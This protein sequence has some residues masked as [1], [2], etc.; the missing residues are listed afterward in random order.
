MFKIV[1]EEV[2]LN[3]VLI[4]LFFISVI[5]VLMVMECGFDLVIL[6]ILKEEWNVFYGLVILNV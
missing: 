5:V 2:V 6:M 4:L 1:V 3:F